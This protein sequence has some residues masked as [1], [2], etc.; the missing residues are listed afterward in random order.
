MTTDAQPTAPDPIWQPGVSMALRV[1]E[2]HRTHRP[3]EG[4]A[5]GDA[6]DGIAR[7]IA[8]TAR[9]L[10]AAVDYLRDGLG[11]IT[12]RLDTLTGAGVLS[13]TND[14]PNTAVNA[15]AFDLMGGI[16]Q[17]HARHL[18]RLIQTYDQLH[19]PN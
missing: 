7:L 6:L 8:H 18:Q 10:D 11:H 19:T 15:V 12:H 16:A 9:E 3:H 5:L 4:T 17:V 1:L 14:I 2:A 13:P